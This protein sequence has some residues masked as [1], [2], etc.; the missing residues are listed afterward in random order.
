MSRREQMI[1]LALR[2]HSN[3]PAR[4]KKHKFDLI[5]NIVCDESSSE[6]LKDFF[7]HFETIKKTIENV[8]LIVCN[9]HINPRG[10]FL[11]EEDVALAMSWAQW[12]IEPLGCGLKENF[13]EDAILKQLYEASKSQRG[14]M[15]HVGLDEVL[16]CAYMYQCDLELDKK[17][18][19]RAFEYLKMACASFHRSVDVPKKLS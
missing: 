18:Y 3:L 2:S 9:S 6:L 14:D 5:N 17:N 15:E 4:L 8:P 11:T 19:Q 7:Q 1:S 12:S 13:I 10:I 16:L